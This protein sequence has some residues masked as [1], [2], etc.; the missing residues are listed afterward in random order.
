MKNVWNLKN[1]SIKI[2]T[3][4]NLFLFF[5]ALFCLNLSGQV[6]Q[7]G[8]KGGINFS[9]YKDGNIENVDYKNHTNYHGGIVAEVKIF[10]NLAIQPELLY[11]TQGA[12]LKQLGQELK[13]EMGYIALPVLLKFYLNDNKL[14]LELGPQASFLVSERNKVDQDNSKTF[15]MAAAAGLSLKLTNT[16]FISARYVAGLTEAKATS[17]VKNSA[18][19]FS[20][21]L[22]F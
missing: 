14:S 9:N 10:K 2:H 6:V 7:L 5:F 3:M 13:N 16:L 1:K 4:K 19:L 8:F 15:E 18:V 11:I 22:L 21:G 20:A 12:T 17:E